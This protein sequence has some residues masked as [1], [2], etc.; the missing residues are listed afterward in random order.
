MY[1]DF[2][3]VSTHPEG[4]KTKPM[5]QPTNTARTNKSWRQEW[6]L[7]GCRGVDKYNVQQNQSNYRLLSTLNWNVSWKWKKKEQ[8]QSR[9]KAN[10]F[11]QFSTEF[12]KVNP[13]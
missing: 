10:Y 2:R 13:R 9:M 12:L 5:L 4:R 3:A 1:I 7:T 8:Q 11:E 6:D